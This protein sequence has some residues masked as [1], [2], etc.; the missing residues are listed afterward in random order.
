MNKKLWDPTFSRQDLIIYNSAVKFSSSII[1]VYEEVLSFKLY[2]GDYSDKIKRFKVV[3]TPNVVVAAILYHIASRSV[4]LIEQCRAASLSVEQKEPWVL[5]I[6]AG[7]VEANE[8]LEEAMC[9]EAQEEAGCS[10]EKLIFICKYLPSCGMS[11][12]ITHVYCGLIT[13]LP[14]A[15]I[16][17]CA[18]EMEN[19]KAIVFSLEEIKNLLVEN[20]I[21]TASALI[22]L[23]WLLNNYST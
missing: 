3:R 16:Y 11:N 4:V 21:I 14:S 9:R 8:D 7:V 23:Q 2:N 22:A 19:I 20:K 1:T 18:H 12:E 6:V 5:D 13:E 17:G 15:E 10:I